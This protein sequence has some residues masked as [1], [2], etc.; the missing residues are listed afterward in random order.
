MQFYSL[1]APGKPSEKKPYL[2][3]CKWM[4]SIRFAA[5]LFDFSSF[6]RYIIMTVK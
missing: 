1:P 5:Q 6:I 4:R 3:F 2:F